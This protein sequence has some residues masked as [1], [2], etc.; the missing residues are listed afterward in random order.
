MS[1]KDKGKLSN[2]RSNNSS[3]NNKELVKRVGNLLKKGEKNNKVSS[4]TSRA[5]HACI[6]F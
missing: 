1:K 3:K 4:F 2:K 6:Q 5:A